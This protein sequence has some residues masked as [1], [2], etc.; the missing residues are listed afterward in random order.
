[1]LPPSEQP[2]ETPDADDAEPLPVHPL[3]TQGE[4]AFYRDL[5]ELLKTHDHQWVAYSGDRRLGFARREADLYE[6]CV[7]QGYK[8]GEF[9]VMA[10]DEALLYDDIEMDPP[11]GA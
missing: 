5:P 11:S 8:L 4:D 2:I 9:A 1:M 10:I 3:L 6:R 7:R